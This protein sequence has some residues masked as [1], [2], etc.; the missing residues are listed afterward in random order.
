VAEIVKNPDNP[1]FGE[2]ITITDQFK[3]K[4]SIMNKRTG[5]K[6]TDF[7]DIESFDSLKIDEIS[8][9]R[10][11]MVILSFK[12]ISDGIFKFL[13]QGNILKIYVATLKKS[14]DGSEE[15]EE[16]QVLL[17][18]FSMLEP[19]VTTSGNL[20]DV[21]ISAVLDKVN[22][23]TGNDSSCEI[24]KEMNSKDVIKEIAERYFD[25]VDF[26]EPN[27][28]EDPEDINPDDEMNWIRVEDECAFVKEV[29][30]HTNYSKSFPVIGITSNGKFRYKNFKRYVSEGEPGYKY[31]F[32]S[33]FQDTTEYD[34]KIVEIVHSGDIVDSSGAFYLNMWRGS[35]VIIPVYDSD[36]GVIPIPY[37]GS[38]DIGL[39]TG[40]DYSNINFDSSPVELDPVY[41]NDNVYPEYQSSKS[42]NLSG[43]AMYSSQKI[44]FT[45]DRT[46]APIEVLDL[47]ML[48]NETTMVKDVF[49][50]KIDEN[51]LES[52]QES[53]EDTRN[54]V[55]KILSG[56]YIIS[57]IIRNFS[58]GGVNTKIEACREFHP[59]QVGNLLGVTEEES[60]EEEG[61]E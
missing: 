6:I 47:I 55:D 45:F 48:V 43:W 44:K 37:E 53:P 30:S 38:V 25:E 28:D 5:K 10:L 49:D 13:N 41:Q 50:E 60:G 12:A 42:R 22:F 2:G 29:L 14:I 46:Y 21:V 32:V 31:R 26:P 16:E 17:Q 27:E 58:I 40:E 35:G 36:I 19:I 20:K 54:E 39:L 8:W 9:C 51:S 15:E 23:I 34:E 56:R 52:S 57:R 4:C 18:D 1:D 3:I 11:P 61:T 33:S 7:F 24:F 59:D